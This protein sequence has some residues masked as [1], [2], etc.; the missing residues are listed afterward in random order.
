MAKLALPSFTQCAS[1][2]VCWAIYQSY[3]NLQIK[4]V[5]VVEHQLEESW[6]IAFPNLREIVIGVGWFS[7]RNFIL[8]ARLN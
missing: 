7:L 6:F 1:G 5:A 3:W 4:V 2:I 8:G